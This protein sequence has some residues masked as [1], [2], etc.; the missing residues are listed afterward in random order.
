MLMVPT[1][2]TKRALTKNSRARNFYPR[3]GGNRIVVIL[4]SREHDSSSPPPPLI[5]VCLSRDSL[6]PSGPC[7]NN[8]LTGVGTHG[9]NTPATIDVFDHRFADA[10][11]R[12]PRRNSFYRVDYA[13]IRLFSLK[14]T[15]THDCVEF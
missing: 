9:K 10:A 14:N 1:D 6:Y 15:V 7:L 13:W 12:A 2:G 8:G 5:P 11:G 4:R 3:F